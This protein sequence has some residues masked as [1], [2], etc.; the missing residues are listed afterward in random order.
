MRFPP[1]VG[2]LIVD[3]ERQMY[4]CPFCGITFDYDYFREE[5][6]LDIASKAL[7]NNEYA[8][9]GRAY[10]F[11]L[12]KEPDNFEALRGKALIAMKVPK[13]THIRRL[14]LYPK[15]NYIATNKEID[16]AIESSRP[17]DHEYF[18]VM[19]D[20]VEAGH[21]YVGEKENNDQS[22]DIVT[23]DDFNIDDED[24]SIR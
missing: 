12:E 14:D 23:Y 13:I 8:S 1:Q 20:I 10:D 18:T 17:E 16:R 5:S 19:K 24:N 3:I 2:N 15:L 9:A 21:E 7:I 22:D 6:V 4:E 11:M